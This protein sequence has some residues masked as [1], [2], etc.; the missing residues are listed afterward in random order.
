MTIKSPPFNLKWLGFK[1]SGGARIKVQ[2]CSFMSKKAKSQKK[3]Y[4]FVEKKSAVLSLDSTTP[5]SIIILLCSLYSPFILC[6]CL[7]FLVKYVI[8]STAIYH[9][10]DYLIILSKHRAIW[11][12]FGNYILL[13][14]NHSYYHLFSVFQIILKRDSICPIMLLDTM[15]DYF[16][17]FIA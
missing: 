4:F 2:F 11:L 8:F 17:L 13:E 15:H 16:S 9:S 7:R 1:L 10:R 14:R 5:I 12:K 6:F 3:E